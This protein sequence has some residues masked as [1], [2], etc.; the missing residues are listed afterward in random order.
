MARSPWNEQCRSLRPALTQ[1]HGRRSGDGLWKRCHD[2]LHCR[3][4]ECRLHLRHRL[5]YD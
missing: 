2:K 4:E 5:Q 3:N 1:L